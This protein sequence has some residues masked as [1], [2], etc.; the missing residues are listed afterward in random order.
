[1][2]LT[3]TE[4]VAAGLDRRHGLPRPGVHG[5]ARRD[6][7]VAVARGVRRA[8]RRVPKAWA[9]L[10]ERRHD[11]S[12]LPIQFALAGMNSH[13]AHDLP[14]ALVATCRQLDTRPTTPGPRG[15]REGQ[16]PAGRVRVRDPPLIPHRGRPG[17]GPT[18]RSGRPPHQRVE[19]RQGARRRLGQRRGAVGAAPRS[20]RW[21]T[22]TGC[23]GPHGRHG[24]AL[25]ADGGHRRP[26]RM[27]PE[28]SASQGPARG[29]EAHCRRG[30]RCSRRRA[31]SEL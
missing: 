8:E 16:R 20:G 22:A 29:D 19:H 6:V 10:F 13:I 28:V 4:Q 18:F 7:R 23:A 2:Y 1:M 24:V 15:L 9:P 31:G 12:V 26:D 5:A 27:A 21:P 30:A 25:P 17:R 3:V 11:H 14:V